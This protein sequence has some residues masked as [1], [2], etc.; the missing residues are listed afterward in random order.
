MM[1]N[2]MTRRSFA[3]M[4]AALV[5]AVALGAPLAATLSSAGDPDHAILE[6]WNRRAAAFAAMNDTSGDESDDLYAVIDAS[7]R[8]I[9]STAA[10]TL[11]GVEIQIW[12][13]LHAGA[14]YL[15]N[16]EAAI[17]RMDAAYLQQNHR[18]FD[19][20]ALPLLT[21]IQSLRAM[22]AEA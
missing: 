18:N 2:Q 6:A 8:I 17:L 5:P 16:D 4:G 14:A 7:E 15:E 22:G 3:A 21:A 10:K 1:N 9:H 11:R 20:N 19:W 12:A 13:A